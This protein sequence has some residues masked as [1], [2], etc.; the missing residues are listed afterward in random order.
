MRV[1]KELKIVESIAHQKLVFKENWMDIVDRLSVCLISIALTTSA[2]LAI[3]TTTF[4]SENDIISG[5][6]IAL[7]GLFG[8]YL[9]YRKLV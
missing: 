9:F 6:L 1:L 8:I 4:R 7:M 2:I 5:V 3:T